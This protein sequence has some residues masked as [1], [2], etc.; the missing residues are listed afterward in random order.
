MIYAIALHLL[1]GVVT[2]AVFTVRMLLF[3]VGFVLL[4]FMIAA[5]VLSSPAGLA[6]L[7]SLVAVQIGYVVGTFTRG[8]IEQAGLAG[9]G[10]RTRRAP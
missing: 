10:V 7:G 5:L 4:E 8:L 2:G 3:L 9:P 6:A 1:A